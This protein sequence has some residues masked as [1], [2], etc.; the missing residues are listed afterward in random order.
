MTTREI[1]ELSGVSVQTVRRTAENDVGY[2][3]EKGKKAVFTEKE[4]IEIMKYLRKRG[5]VQHVQNGQVPVQNGQAVTR[6][7][8][9]E[10][11]KSIVAEMFKQ[12]IPLISNQ[13]KQI[14]IKQDYFSIKGYA[15]KNGIHLAFSD[16]LK[17]GREAAKI[18][19]ER[20]IE[21]RKVDDEQFGQVGSYH[22]DILREV[23]SL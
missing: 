6:S 7:E 22:I 23:F 19:R 5:F 10:F 15:S 16:A 4:S 14:D 11:G 13:V 17:L 12:I 1:A 2:V 18:S 9:A 21:I 8:L 20:E 3:F